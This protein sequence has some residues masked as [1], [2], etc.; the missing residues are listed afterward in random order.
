MFQYDISDKFLNNDIEYYFNIT[1]IDNNPIEDF[2][3]EIEHVGDLLASDKNNKVRF[4]WIEAEGYCQSEV[5]LRKILQN[6][7]DYPVLY[8]HWIDCFEKYG[9]NINPITVEINQVH[10]DGVYFADSSSMKICVI[11][12]AEKIGRL[13]HYTNLCKSFNDKSCIFIFLS[14][15]RGKITSEVWKRILTRA[16][17]DNENNLG[18]IRSEKNF[19]KVERYD[20]E[21]C[22]NL[23]NSSIMNEDVKRKS[24]EIINTL[25]KELR[26]VY[27][28]DLF[29]SYLKKLPNEAA[30]PNSFN[31]TSLLQS[32]YEEAFDGI[33]SH[34][35]GAP[36]LAKYITE[37]YKSDFVKYNTLDKQKREPI[38]DCAWAYGII[39]YAYNDEKDSYY[40]KTIKY[41][42]DFHKKGKNVASPDQIR[43]ITNRIVNMITNADNV[44]EYIFSLEAFLINLSFH[45]I[46]GSLI[47]AIV[48][49]ESLEKIET[50]II[51]KLFLLLCDRYKQNVTVKE[52]IHLVCLLGMEIGKLLS[53]V[54][55]ETV[56]KGLDCFF[57]QVKDGYVCPRCNEYGISVIPVTNFEFSKFVK[58]N[59]YQNYY[60][61]VDKPLNNIAVNYY[62]EIFDF[63]IN[64]LNGH[65]QKNS[66]FLANILKGYDWLQY[67][68]IAYLYVQ[69]NIID[70]E[71]IYKS[72]QEINYP[73]PIRYPAKWA[74]EDNSKNEHPFCNPLQP[75][76]CI[77][78]FEARAYA[79]WL[80]EKIDVPVRIVKYDPDY[81]SIIGSI[82]SEEENKQ[83]VLF[84]NHLVENENF[85]NTVENRKWFYGSDD[86]EI[87]EPS[88]VSIPNSRFSNLYDFLGNVFETQDTKFNYKYNTSITNEAIQFFEKRE[89]VLV[90]Y[91]CACG[92]LQR[93]KANL[94]P[95]YMGQV[96]AFLR[97]QD[98]GFRIV[99]DGREEKGILKEHLTNKKICYSERE[100]IVFNKCLKEDVKNRLLNNIRIE[101]LD[102]LCGNQILKSDVYSCDEKSLV[103][104]SASNEENCSAKDLIMVVSDEKSIFI[105]QLSYVSTIKSFNDATISMTICYPEIPTEMALRKKYKNQDLSYWIDFVKIYENGKEVTYLV[106]KVDIAN[107][108]FTLPKRKSRRALIDGIERKVDTLIWG[109]CKISFL[110]DKMAFK[111]SFFDELQGQLGTNFFLP[112][113][114]NV[115][116]YINYISSSISVT[117]KLDVETIMTAITTIDTSDLHEKINEQKIYKID[118]RI[119]RGELFNE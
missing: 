21:I 9:D 29:L 104:F 38:D 41:L 83:R 54:S 3:D 59:G 45:N 84:K 90:D 10:K 25:N 37:Y 77:N 81:I 86:I 63:I 18:I 82:E 116:D 68:Q 75:V 42:F 1:D 6:K 114:I 52:E 30:V 111:T 98:I 94:P 109:K 11:D 62:K 23:I 26:R 8:L 12:H 4:M 102:E 24:L 92:G 97:N 2:W 119:K 40:S 115:V 20:V 32:I 39:K 88:P 112:D 96:P 36:T 50:N 101:F 53:V 55:N 89:E 31:D 117:E 113:W 69:K 87:R 99:I 46:Q 15:R 95:E 103:L 118:E 13:E 27:Y 71:D 61:I 5:F 44:N 28:F 93:T 43:N 70:I 49:N 19:Y 35:K 107:S 16:K 64:A 76:V 34:V 67:K 110:E 100:N 22:K 72:I 79:K 47:C 105:Y 74:D 91:N 73:H 17:N 106:H 108:Y 66:K 85:I 65:S 78:L 7:N 14:K 51:E 57:R 33:I 80:S 48:I 58:D 60:D 56:T